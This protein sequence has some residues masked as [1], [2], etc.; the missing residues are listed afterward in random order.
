MKVKRGRPK[1]GAIY[2]RK[3]IK[4]LNLNSPITYLMLLKL[5]YIPNKLLL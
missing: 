1:G 5:T 4:V 3:Y 2:F